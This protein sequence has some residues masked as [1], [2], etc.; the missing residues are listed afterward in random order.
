V[1]L[2]AGSGQRFGGAVPK[3]YQPLGGRRVLDWSLEAAR[4]TVDGVVLVVDAERADLAEDV[5]AVVVGGE[6]RADS[7]RAG[8]AAVPDAAEV[9]V[10]HDAARPLAGRELFAR[11]VARVREGADGAIPTVAVTDTIKQVHGGWVATTLDRDELR[12]VQTPQAFRATVLRR[13]HEGAPQATDDAR[14]V[15]AIGGRVAVVDGEQR[16]V[17]ITRADDLAIA[18]VLL[19]RARQ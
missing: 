4:G 10:V 13:A 15:E 5:D 6:Q 2:A 18:E 11:V 14:L 16:N 17:K 7:V 3:Q 9:I 12:A 8:L 19:A 1:V